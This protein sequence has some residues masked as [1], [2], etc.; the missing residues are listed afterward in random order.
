[1]NEYDLIIVGARIAGATLAALLGDAGYRVLLVDRVRFPAP[2]L[3]THF[4]RGAGLLS[5]LGR[6]TL[7]D[8]VL[9][10]GAPPLVCQYIY[11][12]GSSHASS[13]P[14]QAPGEVGYCL[15]VRRITLGFRC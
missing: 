7:L 6:L 13:E 2:T 12:N 5:V 9:A 8:R 11:A 3:S 1:M 4:F 15:S 14:P 10:L